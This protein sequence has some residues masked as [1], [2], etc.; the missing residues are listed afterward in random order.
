M[1]KKKIL[2]I[3]DEV[4]IT[5]MLKLMLEKDGAYE[6]AYENNGMLALQRILEWRPDL[7]ILDINMPETSGGEIL[8][9]IHDIPKLAKLPVIFLTGDVTPDEADQGMTI[10]GYPAFSKPM[11]I[12]KL[13]ECIQSSLS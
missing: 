6:V 5:K 1:D 13:M 4:N 7:L 9:K 12:S 8:A 3:D 10:S 11:N 2:I